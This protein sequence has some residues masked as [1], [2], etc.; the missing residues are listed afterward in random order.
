M[1]ERE[2][3]RRLE[4]ASAPGQEEA[5]E[6]AWPLVRQAFETRERVRWTARHRGPLLALA[7]VGVLAVAALTPPGM[8]VVDRVRDAVGR[9]PSG[10]ALVRLPAPGRLLVL[11]ENGPW[12]V[13]DDGSKRLLGDYQEASW[14]PRGLYVVAAQG[15]RLVTLE[16]ESGKVRWTLTRGAAIRDPRWS[17]GGADTRIAYRVGTSL[18]VVAGDGS[19][20]S[21]LAPRVTPVAPAWKADSHML[22]YVSADGR[23]HVVEADSH[24][25][26]WHTPALARIRGLDFSPDGHLVVL[27]GGNARLYGRRGLIRLAASELPAGHAVIA[28]VALG[29]GEVVYA[30]YDRAN[31]TTTLVRASCF[32]PGP[33]LLRGPSGI[34]KG[35]GRLDDLTLSPDGRWLVASWPA[36]DQL[37]FFPLSRPAKVRAVSNVARE[38]EPGGPSGG[39]APRVAGWAPPAP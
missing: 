23:V 31:D 34:F 33:C 27:A 32:A 4:G 10:S 19:P 26:L 38:F 5:A 1:T 39:P 6:R 35:G 37:L 24:R 8:A 17:G 12:V 13:N 25:E 29:R 28:A 36:V 9:E 22:A 14:S 2:L 30:D 16:P 3:R 7:A 15:Q 21:L 11:S 20:D 18:R